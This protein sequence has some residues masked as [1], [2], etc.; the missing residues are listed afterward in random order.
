MDYICFHKVEI[1][2]DFW[3]V[4]LGGIRIMTAIIVW[5]SSQL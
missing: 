5:K 2:R 1:V 4:T 3:R